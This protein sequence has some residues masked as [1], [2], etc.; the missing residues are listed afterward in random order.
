V[1]HLTQRI[2]T[3]K[4]TKAG[5]ALEFVGTSRA[6][7]ILGIGRDAVSSKCRAGVFPNAEQDAVR[8]PWRIPLCD[9]E[10]YCKKIGRAYE[11]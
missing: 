10:A 1:L 2:N 4:E 3:H 9:I 7:E 8:K 11:E 5:I 6:A